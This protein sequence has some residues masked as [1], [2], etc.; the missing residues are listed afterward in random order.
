MAQAAALRQDPPDIVAGTLRDRL[1]SARLRADRLLVVVDQAEELFSQPWRLTDAEAIRQFHA[2]AELFARLLL[3]AVAQ[4]PA[5]LVLT[6]RSDF[7]DPLM[8]SPFAALLKE[9]Q[10]PLGR[11][12][13]LHPC[14]ERPATV[15]GL[16]LASG[17]AGR[18]V[19]EV[20][21]EESNLPLLEH[22]LERMWQQPR[23][24]PVL[25][26]DAYVA[27]GGVAQAINQAAADCY[28]TLSADE[29]DA[30]RRLFL[31]LVRPGLGSAYARVRGAVP[32]DPAERHVMN[33]FAR[34]DRR[35]LFVGEQAGVP[36]VEVAHEALVHGW[37]T[38]RGWVAESREKLRV[39]D[40]VTD[41]HSSA[42][43]SELIPP[44]TALLQRARDLLADPGDVR[45]DADIEAYMYRSITT[46]EAAAQAVQRRR[47]RVFGAIVAA[48]VFFAALSATTGWFWRQSTLQKR[49][50]EEQQRVAEEQRTRAEN[51]AT[52][53]QNVAHQ[54]IFDIAEGLV[55]QGIA[56]AAVQHV[57][58]AALRVIDAMLSYSPDNAALRRLKWAALIDFADTYARLGE[59]SRQ[60]TMVEQALEIA[61]VAVAA[62][63]GDADWRRELSVSQEKV[64]NVLV[65]QGELTGALAAYR[66]DLAITE[67]LAGRDPGN[68]QWQRDLSVSNNKVGDVLA[69]QGDLPGAL[70]AYRKGL[71]ITETL[72]GRDPG[73]TQW[74]RDL[75]VS[76][77][78]VGNVLVAQG[79]LT[80]VLAA[81]RKSLGI[82]ETLAAHDPGNTQWQLDLSISHNKVGDVLVAQ[83]DLPGALAAYRKALA[84]TE[85]LA[86]RDP[87][88]TQWQRDLSVS[89]EKV[90]DV[91][92]AQGD[93]PG[94]LAAYRKDLAITETL[95]GRDPGNT[96][97]QRDLSVSLGRAANTL[98]QMHEQAEARPLAE[99]A[100]V[101]LR[102]AIARFPDDPRLSR[103]LPY[104]ENLLRRAGGTP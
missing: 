36:V 45:L 31:R 52:L 43:E 58:D 63:S 30:A 3:E 77:G 54:L 26:A 42:A 23:H 19:E 41:W 85:T 62:A 5:S 89:H 72:A 25:T 96:Q 67:T 102:A 78:K 80:G 29:R 100:L 103:N 20:G 86:G 71:A 32:A 84:I 38:L 11:I 15:V 81:Y 12:A 8:H 39:R 51:S 56:A 6:I 74:Q 50:A 1:A 90:G 2:D 87:G 82:R 14:I 18:I 59:T 66:E 16:R 40:A 97:W 60:K 46:A 57:L 98:L 37:E 9:T 95:A 70:A 88:N 61:S 99:R 48:A 13:D 21:P 91:L 69:A 101:S 73:N 104:Y 17:L 28:A 22:A 92:V 65:A 10:V 83:G 76:N 55:D 24:A 64:G 79:D 27:A 4:G 33:L 93:L 75:S 7:F 35:L 49:V 68:T 47:R 94:A 34:Q 53:A 44:G